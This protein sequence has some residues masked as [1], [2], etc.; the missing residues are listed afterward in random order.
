[1]GFYARQGFRVTG[2]FQDG[3]VV[4]ELPLEPSP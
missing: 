2:Q 4:L 3:E 1:L